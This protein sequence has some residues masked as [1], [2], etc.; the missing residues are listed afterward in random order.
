M[1]QDIKKIALCLG[2]PIMVASS[3]MAQ[4]KV[5][6]KVVN[7]A[8]Q[9]VAEVVITCPGCKTVRSAADGS[10]TIEDVKDGSLI[11]FIREGFYT[12]TEY[13]DNAAESKLNVNLIETSNTRY[14]ETTLLPYTKEENNQISSL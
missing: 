4:Q 9:P 1:N 11:S 8:N 14:N 13:V 7:S 2:L 3:A 12:K 6:G 5:T 10:F